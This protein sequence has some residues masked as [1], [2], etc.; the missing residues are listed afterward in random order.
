MIW[1]SFGRWDSAAGRW[2][3]RKRI[4]LGGRWSPFVRV[5]KRYPSYR[6]LLFDRMKLRRFREVEEEVFKRMK[7]PEDPYLRG[8]RNGVLQGLRVADKLLFHGEDGGKNDVQRLGR[9][10]EAEQTSQGDRNAQ[11][12]PQEQEAQG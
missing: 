11:G 1:I 7:P 2:F 10:G 12:G 8:Y 3:K 5:R 9:G 6:R 4:R